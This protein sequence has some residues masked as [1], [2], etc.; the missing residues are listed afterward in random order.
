MGTRSVIQRI[1]VW[2]KV[3]VGIF[4]LLLLAGF[5]GINAYL[6]NLVNKRLR[7]MVQE[8]SNGLYRLDYSDIE[9]NAYS[10][11]VTIFKAELIPD[12]VV[13]AELQQSN[14]APRFLVSGKTERLTLKNVRWLA[15][16]NK[17]VLKIS[18]VLIEHPE[19]D[20]VQYKSLQK[21]SANR[22][23]GA[24]EFISKNVKDLK[25][26]SFSI[27]DA[28]IR[29]QSRDTVAKDRTINT[30]EHLDIGF[31]GVH[32]EEEK[33]LAAENYYIALKEY[34]HRT[35]DSLYWIGISGFTYNSKQRKATLD[36]FYSAPRYSEVNFAKRMGYQETRYECNLKNITAE[37]FDIALLLEENE[38]RMQ[39][40]K[41]GGGS[42]NLYMN[43]AY[44]LPRQDKK[45]VVISQVIKNLGI[46]M[47]IDSIT[48]SNFALSYKE[49]NPLSGK[50]ATL[51]FEN[52]SGRVV[53]VTNLS[54]AIAKDHYMKV[55]IN[56]RFLGS[57][58][59]A[60]IRFDLEKPDGR[61]NATLEADQV[62][63]DRLNVVLAPMALIEAREGNLEKLESSVT[64]DANHA[65]ADVKLLYRDLK[66]NILENKGNGL[67]KKGLKSIFANILVFDDNPKDGSLRTARNVRKSR[68][69]A[70]SFFNLAWSAVAAG[71]VEIIFKEKGIKLP[72]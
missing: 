3:T 52:F 63:A 20:L 25:I 35:A 66:I 46:P 11:D 72:S 14:Q 15:F 51:K 65:V 43:R 49:F 64:G 53:N 24:F 4:L 26:G 22:P 2:L 48:I 40:V 5:I 70:K 34:K 58:I 39:R 32:F 27:H 54:S 59:R 7:E 60:N 13:F 21:D 57:G 56:A 16:M 1:P 33:Q 19:F 17:R 50:A 42:A 9:L 45:D 23:Q 38:L 10:G 37:G 55:N 68:R 18:S 6:N 36:T 8:S 28:V 29:Y 47:L 71:I 62:F 31:T 69:F 30:I 41:V 12:T 67:E 61:F 44:P